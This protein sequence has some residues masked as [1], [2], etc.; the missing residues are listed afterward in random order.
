M[1]IIVALFY[2]MCTLG[3]TVKKENSAQDA[4][5]DS[6][7]IALIN[8]LQYKENKL[9]RPI[10]YYEC[11]DYTKT[12]LRFPAGR[13]AQNK[14]YEKLDSMLKHRNRVINIWHVGDSHVQAGIFSH[15]VRTNFSTMQPG[16]AGT[17]GVLFPFDMAKTNWTHNYGISYTGQWEVQRNINRN[18]NLRFGMTGISAVTSDPMATTTIDLGVEDYPSW[19]MDRMKVLGYASSSS[20]KVG[21]TL[22]FERDT[23]WAERD[24]ITGSYVVELPKRTKKATAVFCIPKGDT[25]TLQGLI[26]ENDTQGIRYFSSG[27]NG[28][29]VPTWNKCVDIQRDL[30]NVRPDLVIF[31]IGVNDAAVPYGRFSAEEFKSAYRILIAKIKAVNPDCAFL[32]VTNNDI[33]CRE[34]KRKIPNRNTDIVQAAFYDLARE[35]GGAVW[36]VYDFMGGFNSSPI[37]RDAGLMRS[38]LIHF[39]Q[40]GYELLGDMLYNAIIED[41]TKNRK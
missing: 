11:I 22:P 19:S 6:A 31:A 24:S 1:T 35:Y 25:F 34:K 3:Q 37:W 38:D 21:V 32:F 28:D 4:T 14:F 2:S 10:V 16:L 40:T 33:Y 5:Y 12:G 7:R 9:M 17:R 8:K 27:I 23:L 13:V 20:V 36:D 39:T 30:L 41:Y 29:A 18:A 15:R 26:P